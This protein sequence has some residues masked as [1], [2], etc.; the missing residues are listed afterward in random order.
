MGLN[1]S[2]TGRL[3]ALRTA[4]RCAP[5]PRRGRAPGIAPALASSIAN[6]TTG[7][8]DSSIERLLGSIA[9]RSSHPPWQAE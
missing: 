5:R 3:D 6:K 1:A 7:N 4:R 2:G 8:H 9:I